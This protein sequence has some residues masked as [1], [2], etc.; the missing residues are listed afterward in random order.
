[1][2]FEALNKT[3]W[4]EFLIRG[5]N[6]QRSC[7]HAVTLIE[8]GKDRVMEQFDL[9]ICSDLVG[10]YNRGGATPNNRNTTWP[11]VREAGRD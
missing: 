7:G 10:P 8:A 9:V 1:M 5:E 6:L 2:E 3:L 11:G 4:N